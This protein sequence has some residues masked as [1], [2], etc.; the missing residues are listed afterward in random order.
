MTKQ[1]ALILIL[2]TVFYSLLAMQPDFPSDPAISPDGTTV[3]FEYDDDLWL[4]SFSGG[5]ARRLTATEAG[6]W[7][8]CWSPDGRWIAF[9]SN[10]EGVTYPYLI[11]PTDGSSRLIIAE[12]FSVCDWFSDSANLLCTKYSLAHG[13]SFFKVPLDGSRPSLIAEIGDRFASLSP[14]NKSIVFN[15]RGDP[16]RESYQGSVA[17][18]LWRLDITSKK[19]SRLTNTPYTE[20]YPRWSHAQAKAGRNVLFYCASDGERFQVFRV[21]N[22]DFSQAQQLTELKDWSARDI[23]VARQNDRLVFEYFNRIWKLDESGRA[24]ELQIEIPQDLWQQNIRQERMRNEFSSFAISPDE[25]LLAFRHKYD[26]FFMPRKG[27]EVRQVT[28]SQASLGDLEFLDDN[29]TLLFQLLDDG[30]DKLFTVKCDSTSMQVQPL[31]WFGQDKLAVERF[32]KDPCGKWVI[33]YG[34]ERYS[35]RIAIADKD[36]AN[37]RPLTVN[38]PVVS[39]LA[40]NPSGDYAVYATTREDVWMRELWLYDVARDSHRKIMNDDSW[41]SKLTWTADSKSI[42]ISR[43]GGIFRLDLVPRDELELEVDNWKEIFAAETDSVRVI[44]EERTLDID[45]SPEAKEDKTEQAKPAQKEPAKPLDLQILWEGIEKRLYPV[46]SDTEQYLSVQKVI[47]DST[48][49][50]IAEKRTG[51]RNAELRK[52]NIYGAGGKK[53]FDLGANIGA[54]TWVKDTIYYVKDGKILYYNTV[55]GSKGEIKTEFDYRYDVSLLNTRVF[56]EVWS[57]FGLNF[58]DPNMHGRNWQQQYELYHPFAQ[59]ARSISDIATIVNEMIGDVNSSHTGFYP[60]RDKSDPSRQQ[61]WLGVELD[62]ATRLP[63]GIRI[64]KV[65]P[66]SRLATLYNIKAGDIITSIDGVDITSRTP[67][68]SLMLDKVGKRITLGYISNGVKKSAVLTGLNWSENRRLFYDNQVETSKATVREMTQGRVGYIHIPSMGSR[69]YDNFFRDLFRDNADKEALIIDVRGNTGGHIHDRIISLLNKTPYAYSTSRRYSQE[70]IQEPRRAWT[71][72]SIVLVDEGSFS[73]GEIFPT[74]Y[75]ELKLGKL[76][77]MPSSGSVIG[78]WEYGLMDGS[79]MRLP[80]SG[81]YRMDGTNM[82]G[83][84]VVPDILVEISPEDKIA[85]RDTQLLRA[86]EEI[87]KDIR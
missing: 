61:A 14:D 53:E 54:V 23:S 35:G 81:W 72:P 79:S 2:M 7:G 9:N 22:G 73:D 16:Y 20:R 57:R 48:F 44:E 3:C 75:Q 38:R 28:F 40:F 62:Y 66:A 52:I 60:R 10:R 86:I 5:D 21:T 69:D 68:D 24:S 58:Y 80:G 47:S 77:G 41:I 50:Y 6:E 82:E 37:I 43:S 1:R 18:D 71:R 49:W 87:M 29:R 13:N 45:L 34:D 83:N 11:D 51:E 39:N 17:G 27:G 76:V 78:T 12:S 63:A 8:P 67:V 25:L 19:Y 46:V 70:R 26:T 4:V 42:L 85:G 33:Y 56:E 15:R 32:T 59:K 64:G 65:Y 74:V 36:L 84:G 30:R 55:K 31:Q